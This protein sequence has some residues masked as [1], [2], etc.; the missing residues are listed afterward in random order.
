MA[1]KKSEVVFAFP[2]LLI[3]NSYQ[4]WMN[5]LIH[6]LL[7]FLS[8]PLLIA[9]LQGASEDGVQIDRRVAGILHPTI[10]KTTFRRSLRV[11]Q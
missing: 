10:G 3:S 5:Q 4:Q 7:E 8:F 9:S 1:E 6:L 2:S 11:S